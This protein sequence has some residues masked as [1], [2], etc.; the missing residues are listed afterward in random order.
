MSRKFKHNKILKL[1]RQQ[2]L[3]IEDEW[4][5]RYNKFTNQIRLKQDNISYEYN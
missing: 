1:T 2:Q 5:A 3:M 4:Y